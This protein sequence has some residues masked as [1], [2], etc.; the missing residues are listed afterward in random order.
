[1]SE[2]L[3]ISGAIVAILIV[4]GTLM[5]LMVW[6]RKKE[7]KLEEPDYRAFYVMGIIWVP[8]GIVFMLAYFLLDIPFVIGI[9]LFAM[10]LTYLIIGL[11]NR[12][13]WKKK[14]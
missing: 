13:K 9:P 4:V 14:R 2:W 12:D 5:T 7:G 6:K 11:A 8:A 3:P 1:M 10:G